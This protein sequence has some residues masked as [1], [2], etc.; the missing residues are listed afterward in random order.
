MWEDFIEDNKHRDLTW[1]VE[2]LKKGKYQFWCADGSYHRSK[3]PNISPVGWM[4]CSTKS[5]QSM[6]RQIVS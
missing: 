6:F 2:G 3:A 1:L 4:C 5:S